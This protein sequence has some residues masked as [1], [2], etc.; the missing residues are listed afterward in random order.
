MIPSEGNIVSRAGD[1]GKLTILTVQSFLGHDIQDIFE[2]I[3]SEYLLQKLQSN[4]EL[5]RAFIKFVEKTFRLYYDDGLMIDLIGKKN[6]VL[7]TN[8]DKT[9]SLVFLDPHLIRKVDDQLV[10][11]SNI[12]DEYVEKLKY[13]KSIYDRIVTN[14]QQLQIT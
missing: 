14:K 9:N 1:D 4:T 5:K 11:N 2:D 3:E 12:V 7:T 6:L 8:K 13:L 10:A